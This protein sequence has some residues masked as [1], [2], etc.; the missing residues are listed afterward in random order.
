MNIKNRVTVASLPLMRNPAIKLAP[1]KNKA[2]QIYNQQTRKLDQNL[3]G[4]RDVTESEAKVQKLGFVV[5]VKNLTPEQQQMLK[6][7]YV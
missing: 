1:N 2:L 6:A 4:K 5:F 3:Q 7:I